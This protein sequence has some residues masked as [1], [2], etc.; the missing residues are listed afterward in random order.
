MIARLAGGDPAY[1]DRYT[2][3][4][5]LQI[6]NEILRGVEHAHELGVLHRD[7]KPANVMVGS[8]GEVAIMDWGLAKRVGAAEH[9]RST[10]LTSERLFETHAGALLGTPG[11]MS[12]E[13]AAGKLDELDARSDIYSLAVVF[14]EFLSLKHPRR[15]CRSVAELIAE[16]IEQPVSRIQTL[17]DFGKGRAPATLAHFVRHGLDRDPA[18]R[19]P[20]AKAMR[21]RLEAVRDGRAPIECHVTFPQ[22]VL[23][24]AA[25]WANRHPYILL[26]GFVVGAMGVLAGAATLGLAVFH[27]AGR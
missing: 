20:N 23:D 2:P 18:L 8:L 15:H 1:L 13:Q 10:S 24:G 9:A 11:Y 17:T 6:C 27:F 7:L 21:E 5:R 16:V 14:Y 3:E 19:Y 12:P 26:G 4:Y 22:R 25:R